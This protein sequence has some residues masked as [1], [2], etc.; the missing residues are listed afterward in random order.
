M[1]V[2]SARLVLPIKYMEIRRAREEKSRRN[3]FLCALAFLYRLIIQRFSWAA[4]FFVS[5]LQWDVKEWAWTVT[6]PAR[7]RTLESQS[8]F[9]LDLSETNP[10]RLLLTA[11][12]LVNTTQLCT[13][14]TVHS[15]PEGL[16]QVY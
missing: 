4:A 11:V 14:A 9:H 1:A 12:S 13:Y 8:R 10:A 5:D 3:T 7:S 2:P 6:Q 16:E 15:D